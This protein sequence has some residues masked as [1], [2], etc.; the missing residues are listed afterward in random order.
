MKLTE[1]HLGMAVV[2][3]HYGA[4]IVKAINEHAAEVLFTDGRK[5]VEPES[6]ALAP[7]EAQAQVSGLQ[8][9]LAKFIE[10]TVEALANRLGLEK[11][12]THARE[13]ASKWRGGKC[14]LHPRD[15]ALATKE[16]E[17]EVFFHKIVMVRNNLRVLEQRINASETLTSAEKFDWQQYITKCYGSLTTFN[18]LFKDKEDQF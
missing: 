16:L 3:P 5:P 4:G 10:Q 13:L 12:E 8:I 18:L 2:H 15:P 11:P 14:V 9:P 17:L 7:A 1:L 6:S